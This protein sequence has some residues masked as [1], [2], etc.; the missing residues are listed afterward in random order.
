MVDSIGVYN[1][2]DLYNI[3][4]HSVGYAL[5]HVQ[6][7]MGNFKGPKFAVHA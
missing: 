4:V 2:P 1:R 7:F 3:H 6:K 5:T